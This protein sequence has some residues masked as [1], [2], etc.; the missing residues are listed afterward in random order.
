MPS[1]PI[2]APTSESWFRFHPLTAQDRSVMAALRSMVKP[3]KGK[4]R[5]SAARAPFDALMSGIIAP[6][7]AS[8]ADR[9]RCWRWAQR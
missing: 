3:N 6:T 7:P 1:I 8:P 9:K 4:L 5:G 2:G